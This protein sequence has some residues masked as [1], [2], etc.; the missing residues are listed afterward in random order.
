MVKLFLQR[1]ASELVEL[2]KVEQAPEARRKED[3]HVD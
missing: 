2:G 1:F 3:D